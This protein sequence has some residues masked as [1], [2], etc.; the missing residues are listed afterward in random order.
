MVRVIQCDEMKLAG[1]LWSKVTHVR[2]P[3]R[4]RALEATRMVSRN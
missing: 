2:T 3:V 4:G 1:I